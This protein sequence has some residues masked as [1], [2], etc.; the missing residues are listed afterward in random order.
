MIIHYFIAIDVLVVLLSF[1]VAGV[2][3]GMGPQAAAAK[4]GISV[5]AASQITNAFFDRFKEVKRWV[6]AVKR[7]T[8]F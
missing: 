5:P 3:Y 8:I 6:A 1:L 7:L 2:L 4:L